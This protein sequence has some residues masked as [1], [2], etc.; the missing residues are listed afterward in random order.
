MIRLLFVCTGNTCRSPLA[1]ALTRLEAR[2]RGLEVEPSSAGTLAVEGAPASPQSSSSAERRGADL[3]SHRARPLDTDVLARS[4]LVLAMTPAHLTVLRSG[5]G[6]ELQVGLVTDYLPL[7]HA[8]HGKPVADPFG[9]DDDEY[10][11]VARLLEHCI[12]S[13][14]DRLADSE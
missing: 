3:S 6:R 5:H 1:E 14:L 10:E 7:D 12:S 9:G 2:K 8:S 4:D 13:L 11:E